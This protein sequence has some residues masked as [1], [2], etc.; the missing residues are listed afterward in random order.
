MRDMRDVG[1]RGRG[2]KLMSG[3]AM[4]RWTVAV[5]LNKVLMGCDEGWGVIHLSMAMIRESGPLL[6]D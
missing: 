5:N 2:W 1:L 3:R 4:A 6:F